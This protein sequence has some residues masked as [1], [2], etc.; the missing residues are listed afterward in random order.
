MLSMVSRGCNPPGSGQCCRQ[1]VT[2][3]SEP[4]FEKGTQSCFVLSHQARHVKFPNFPEP[5]FE[6]CAMKCRWNRWLQITL[7]SSAG[8]VQKM[9]GLRE[10]VCSTCSQRRYG[11][12][13]SIFC[14]LVLADLKIKGKLICRCFYHLSRKATLT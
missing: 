13:G 8:A 10:A 5:A 11:R 12:D 6:S 9:G 4:G 14:K 1:S 3:V 2:A 7:C